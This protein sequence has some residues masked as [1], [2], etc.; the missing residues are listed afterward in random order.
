MLGPCGD[1][2]TV[3]HAN[4]DTLDI[5][6]EAI[7]EASTPPSPWPS[8]GSATPN[9]VIVLKTLVASWRAGH[10]EMSIGDIALL[11]VCGATAAIIITNYFGAMKKRSRLLKLAKKKVGKL[12]DALTTLDI[13]GAAAD[14]SGTRPMPRGIGIGRSGRSDLSER[15]DELLGDGFGT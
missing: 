1:V 7:G 4:E 8:I 12:R 10:F 11:V 15:V 3:S 14:S 5:V 13:E 2:Y 9:I 6:E